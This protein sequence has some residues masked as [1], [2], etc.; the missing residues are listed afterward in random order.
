MMFILRIPLQVTSD[1]I[2]PAGLTPWMTSARRG[3]PSWLD[4][5]ATKETRAEHSSH[6]IMHSYTRIRPL[7]YQDYH[8]M[9][10]TEYDEYYEYCEHDGRGCVCSQAHHGSSCSCMRPVCHSSEHPHLERSV[11]ER[12]S[13]WFFFPLTRSTTESTG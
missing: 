5:A 2:W 7:L 4:S 12:T 10:I 8:P 9:L 13:Q 1:G 3:N 6:L 11:P